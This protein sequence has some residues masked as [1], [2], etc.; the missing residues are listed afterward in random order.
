MQNMASSAHEKQHSTTIEAA[1]L[2]KKG[3]VRKLM[4]GHFCA[5]YDDLQPLLDEARSVFTDTVIAEDG[6][7][8][9]I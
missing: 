7:T 4:I 5:R 8:I 1:T 2:A 3:N 6:M 9:S